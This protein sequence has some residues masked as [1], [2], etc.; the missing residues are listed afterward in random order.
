[1]FLVVAS[2]PV[3]AKSMVEQEGPLSPC[4]GTPDSAN[5]TLKKASDQWVVEIATAFSEQQALDMFNRMKQEHAD[6][7]GDV[8]PIVVEQCN[9]SMGNKPQ[10]SARVMA[11]SQD[12][13]NSLC[14]KLQQGGGACL[15]QKD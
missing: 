6:V 3:V 1:M 2:L 4:I 7:L 10:Y 14:G 11:E 13:A 5:D 12:E 9:L 8:E 15:V